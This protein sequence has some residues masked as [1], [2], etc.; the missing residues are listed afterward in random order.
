MTASKTPGER[1]LFC[2]LNAE[3]YWASLQ[4]CES[5]SVMI[6]GTVFCSVKFCSYII[7][8]LRYVAGTLSGLCNMALTIA[9]KP[10]KALQGNA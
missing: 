7:L 3:V 2:V 4:V 6:H 10:S 8:C 5:S 1:L 9:G